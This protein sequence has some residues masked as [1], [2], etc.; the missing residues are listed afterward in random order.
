VAGPLPV[1][2]LPSDNSVKQEIW[3]KSDAVGNVDD[4][5]SRSSSRKTRRRRGGSE[6]GAAL[7]EFA[8]IVPLLGML[9]MGIVDLGRGYRLKTRLANAAREGAAFAQFFPAR[10]DSSGPTCA[11]P[12]NVAFAVRTEEAAG[13]DAFTVHV[14]TAADARPLTG[15]DRS[16]VAAGTNVIV[17]ASS[18]FD[19]MTPI[20]AALVGQR[21]TLRA[22]VEVVVQG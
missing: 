19:V 1:T 13:G 2:V 17:S 3:Y 6:E 11:D 21:L 5:R 14:R 8:L 12:G 15:C 10:V 20:V 9:A 22:D 7:L 18:S 4:V 16:T